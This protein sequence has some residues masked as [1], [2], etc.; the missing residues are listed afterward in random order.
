MA[1]MALFICLTSSLILSISDSKGVKSV[2]VRI[3]GWV[4]EDAIEMR[5]GGERG[6]V[7]LEKGYVVVHDLSAGDH[8]A[9]S[10]SVPCKIEKETVDGVTY[11]TTWVGNQIIN[12]EPR[13]KVSPLPF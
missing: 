11:T 1:S 3:P 8:G 13:G 5:I 7:L 6:Q 9:L 10:F 2:R 12:I 4:D